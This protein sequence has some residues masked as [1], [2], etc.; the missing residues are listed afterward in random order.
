MNRIAALLSGVCMAAFAVASASGSSGKIPDYISADY[1]RDLGQGRLVTAAPYPNNRVDDPRR[2][3][4]GRLWIPRTPVGTRTPIRE[5]VYGFPGPSSYGAPV[6]AID[7]VIY[8][9]TREPLPLVTVSPWVNLDSQNIKHLK[10]ERPWIRRAPSV[11][12]DL[13]AAQVQH[14]TEQGYIQKV[15]THVNPATLAKITSAGNAPSDGNAIVRRPSAED[16]KPRAVIR[17]KQRHSKPP[18]VEAAAPT[19]EPKPEAV[20]RVSVPAHAEAAPIQVV[21]AE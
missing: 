17:V 1:T 3:Q 20:V 21:K 11:L 2:A 9:Q 8:V 5:S 13:R 7:D 10:R 6:G 19:T 4:N 14:L 12:E 15:R 16:I 18:E